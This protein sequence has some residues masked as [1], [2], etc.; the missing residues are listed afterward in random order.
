MQQRNVGSSKK[1]KK[2]LLLMKKLTFSCKL[3]TQ[4]QE[5]EGRA[6]NDV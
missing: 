4:D 3:F 1:K 6:S 5:C 2:D